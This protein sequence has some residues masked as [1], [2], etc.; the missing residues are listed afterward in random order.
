[1]SALPLAR[2]D[3]LALCESFDELGPEA[4][5]LNAGWTTA[6]LAAHLVARD[7][8]PDS[9][10]GLVVPALAGWSERVRHSVLRRPYGEVVEDLRIGPPKWSPLRRPA[11][12]RMGNTHEFFVHY[13]DVRR[14]SDDWEP[15]RLDA[16]DEA[17]LWR[18]V[19]WFGR[20]AFRRS[21]VGVTLRSGDQ[22][23]TVHSGTPALTIT[24]P[25]GEILLYAFGRQEQARVELDG[26]PAAV[27]ALT[28]TK[29]SW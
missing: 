21:P 22:T 27:K 14:C 8:R 25:P 13:E 17:D 16:T 3:R 2:R 4:P 19:R 15:R 28:A 12:D 20:R 10:P 5:T 24:G 7:R 6:D 18:V 1:M 11:A 9:V 23:F 29:L 26:D